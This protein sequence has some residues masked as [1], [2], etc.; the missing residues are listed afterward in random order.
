[1]ENYIFTL[2]LKFFNILLGFPSQP[3]DIIPDLYNALIEI[4]I[5]YDTELHI[6]LFE[7]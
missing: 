6:Q 7:C 2:G 5:A 4:D 3:D 1:M